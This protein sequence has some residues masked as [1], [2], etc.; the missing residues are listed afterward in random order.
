[1]VVFMVILLRCH[2][3]PGI[4][5]RMNRSFSSDLSSLDFISGVLLVNGGGE[6]TAYILQFS[7]LLL[8]RMSR[9][10]AV[11]NTSHII[12]YMY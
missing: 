2:G 12:A 3:P 5:C 9:V 10:E 7:S 6:L 11:G 4:V 1:M 8:G